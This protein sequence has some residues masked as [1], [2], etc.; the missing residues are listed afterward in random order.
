MFKEDF[1]SNLC[2]LH[3]GFFI[4]NQNKFKKIYNVKYYGIIVIF[5]KK[6]LQNWSD[7]IVI[8]SYN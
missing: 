6:M 7:W 5:G 4:Q 2:E 8:K 1:T 3:T